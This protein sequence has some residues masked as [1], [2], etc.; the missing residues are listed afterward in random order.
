M[1]ETRYYLNANVFS[2]AT[3]SMHAMS[4]TEVKLLSKIEEHTR[5]VNVEDMDGNRF[6]VRVEKLSTEPIYIELAP[7][8][9]ITESFSPY[10][11]SFVYH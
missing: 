2:N 10:K 7:V 1:S 9:N 11:M 3:G 6:P 4:G 5:V 8:I